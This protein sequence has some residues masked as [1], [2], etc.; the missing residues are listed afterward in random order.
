MSDRICEETDHRIEA[1][2]ATEVG[3]KKARV[4]P[5]SDW[6]IR[7][8]QLRTSA[9][10]RDTTL[11]KTPPW[12][13]SQ[14]GRKKK[15]NGRS[16]LSK[17]KRKA[18]KLAKAWTN[19]GFPWLEDPIPRDPND[20]AM[21]LGSMSEKNIRSNPNHFSYFHR[22]EILK[23]LGFESYAAYIKSQLW[24]RIR[25]RVGNHAHIQCFA[26]GGKAYC[27]HHIEYSL[28]TL[29]GRNPCGLVPLC[30]PCHTSIE[31]DPSGTKVSVA[32]A[33]RRLRSLCSRSENLN[34][35]A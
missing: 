26:C 10:P 32:D 25:Q 27:V 13:M 35:R 4:I 5:P 17:S 9:P 14:T 7:K 2:I 22:N 11:T 3:P 8:P 28:E 19:A 1:M 12:R 24:R 18:S 16:R 20:R 6:N 29:T 30:D 21:R 15:K 23:S 31:F 33:A 34:A